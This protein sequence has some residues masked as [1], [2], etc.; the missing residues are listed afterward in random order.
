MSNPRL[1]VVGGPLLPPLLEDEL[2]E[3]TLCGLLLQ[4]LESS[5]ID[6]AMEFLNLGA[7]KQ[8]QIVISILVD[9]PRKR[10]DAPN[11]QSVNRACWQTLTSRICSIIYCSNALE[12][13]ILM[14]LPPV[15][16]HNPPTAFVVFLLAS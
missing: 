7:A 8:T 1:S 10:T 6:T 12:R 3:I 15:C 14:F 5:D 2:T 13:R 9:R 4:R 11:E 16:H